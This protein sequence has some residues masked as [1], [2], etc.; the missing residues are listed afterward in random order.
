MVHPSLLPIGERVHQPSYERLVRGVVGLGIEVPVS[1]DQEPSGAQ[2]ARRF[3]R[4]GRVIADTFEE[5]VRINEVERCVGERKTMAHSVLRKLD[6]RV[7]ATALPSRLD[8]F[9]RCVEANE[10]HGTLGVLTG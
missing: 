10:S 1:G 9:A 6:A 3:P 2:D 8:A 4:E 7:V 5:V